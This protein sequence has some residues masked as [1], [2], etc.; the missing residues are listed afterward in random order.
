MVLLIKSGKKFLNQT[1]NDR[2]HFLVRVI[3]V[4]KNEKSKSAEKF[5]I[6]V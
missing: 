1:L 6:R 5:S 4:I 2:D 3:M